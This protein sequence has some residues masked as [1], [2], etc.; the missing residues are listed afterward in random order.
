MKRNFGSDCRIIAIMSGCFTQRGEPAIFDKYTRAE[1]ALGCGCDLV[2]ELPL[3]HSMSGAEFFARAGV[4]IADAIGKIDLLFFGSECGELTRLQTVARRMTS[5]EFGKA[6]AEARSKDKGAQ[7][8]RL[9]ADIY[10]RLFGDEPILSGSN[11][12]LALEYLRALKRFG[13][14]IRPY[15]IKR[16]G[17]E[18][19]STDVSADISTDCTTDISNDNIAGISPDSISGIPT[20]S[21]DAAMTETA[22]K[23]GELRALSPARF[24]SATAIRKAILSGGELS[25][26]VP[27]KSAE[28]AR[29]EIDSGRIHSLSKLDKIV[30]A[31]IRLRGQDFDNCIEGSAS[32]GARL[33]KAAAEYSTVDD[34]VNASV[35]R[36]Y[37]ASRVRRVLLGGMLGIKM[38]DCDELPAYTNLLGANAVG[39]ELLAEIRKTSRLPVVTRISE[40]K[41]LGERARAQLELEKR[42]AGL[43][44]LSCD[45]PQS[46]A[47]ILRAHPVMF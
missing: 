17:G 3:P 13:S 32:I 47:D 44:A 39:R 41:S 21:I 33:R 34:I 22:K 25:V 14:A 43:Y 27:D 8:G 29:R 12:L 26:L 42:A 15:A 10:R 28:L 40:I 45:A 38:S 9:R 7:T 19:N 2:L 11:D 46:P 16:V 1:S 30:S 20:D 24:A 4:Y 37:S 23:S 35:E 36:R 31:F 18:Y 5:D 6:C